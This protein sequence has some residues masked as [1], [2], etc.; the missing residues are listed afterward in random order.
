MLAMLMISGCEL[1]ELGLRE[2]II[3]NRKW[4]SGEEY[5]IGDRPLSCLVDYMAKD[6]GSRLKLNWAVSRI[7]HDAQGA[8][9][10]GPDGA[11]VRARRV[12]LTVPISVL[13]ADSIVF[14]PPLP[15]SK[16]AAISRLQMSNA[17]KVF[18]V[19][20]SAFWP[21]D[22]FDVVCTDCL[23]PE[24]WITSY[25]VPQ[26]SGGPDMPPQHG[27]EQLSGETLGGTA[28]ATG[29]YVV[30][31]FAAGKRAA[32]LGQMREGSLLLKFLQQLDRIFGTPERARPATG[33]FLR[34]Y[35]VDWSRV[36]YIGG[37]YSHP[38]LGAQLGDRETLGEPVGDTLFFAGEASHPSV[39]PCMQ[40]A[41]ETGL[42]AAQQV[43]SS[44]MPPGS[45]L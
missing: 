20:S 11:V 15:T 14:S 26:T 42:R 18:A 27:F 12:V 23:V 29:Q 41:L 45:K 9:L 28:P 33:A 1:G 22:L 39:N 30:T 13:K 44:R 35:V 24:F 16:L 3:E 36:P 21:E 40:A 5:L 31:G 34:G 17:V 38:S 4:N 7:E 6:L 10:H 19:F 8:T 32:A 2:T 25:P 37:A 43:L